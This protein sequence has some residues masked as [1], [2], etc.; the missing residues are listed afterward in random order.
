MV[1]N[2]LTVPAG[3]DQTAIE[4]AIEDGVDEYLRGREPYI[5]GLSVLPRLDNV[6]QGA[7]KDE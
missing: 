5:E 2:G 7:V 3:A 6:T 1:V 4:Q